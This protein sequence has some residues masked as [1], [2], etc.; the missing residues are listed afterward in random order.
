MM[1]IALL[2]AGHIGQTIARLLHATGDYAVTVMDKNAAYLKV[3]AAEGIATAEVDSE[4][5]TALMNAVRGKD[6]V[7][8]ALP[9]HLAITAAQAALE[10]GCHYFD[11]TEDVA[12]TKAIKEMA[13]GAKTAFM[14]QCGLAPGFIT[15]AATHVM[16]GLTDLTDVRLRVGALPRYPSNRLQ[17]NLT[18]STDGLIN[19]Y[20]NPCEAVQN[21]EFVMVPPMEQVE[22]LTV[23]GV[24]YEAFN[25]SGGLGSLGEA[26][27][28]R[29][30]NVNYKTI[31]YPGHCKLVKFLLHDLG[32]IDHREQLCEVFDRSIPATQDDVI[33]ILCVAIGIE[34]GKLV[35]KIDARRVPAAT[36]NGK[37]W[38]GIQITT[39]AGVCAMLDLLKDDQLPQKGLVRMEDVRYDDFISNRFGQYYVV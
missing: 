8:N 6:A 36:I 27:A 11:L 9:Y 38:T 29:A 7:V 35:E 14:P 5:K 28:G 30:R 15:I 18:W 19:E 2:G 20:C 17:Y 1:K 37:H 25:T 23:D 13:V 10:C 34:N 12:A 24:E 39:A 22:R 16:K 31:R 3:L 26:L 4:S 33:V 32:F 21:G